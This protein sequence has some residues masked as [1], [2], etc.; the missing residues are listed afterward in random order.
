MPRE[1]LTPALILDTLRRLD[2]HILYRLRCVDYVPPDLRVDKIANGRVY[3]SGGRTSGDPAGTPA[4]RAEVTVVGFGTGEQGKWWLTGLRW[5]WRS[6][7]D[8]G[9]DGGEPEG[10]GSGKRFEGEERQ[11]ILDM[12]NGE[13]LPPRA[14]SEAEE[15]E[16]TAKR[17]PDGTP[18]AGPAA[19]PAVEDASVS[20]KVDAPLVRLHNFIRT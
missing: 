16:D 15:R 1:P 12:A 20:L 8:C 2:A 3:F 6:R 18:S 5:C 14:V 11:Q 17:I 9:S 19:V 10:A 7:Q 13:I 4:W